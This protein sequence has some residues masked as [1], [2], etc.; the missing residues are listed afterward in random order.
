MN[1]SA[2]L[3]PQTVLTWKASAWWKSALRNPFRDL[4]RGLILFWCLGSLS[5]SLSVFC[6]ALCA[7][8]CPSHHKVHVCVCLYMHSVL[9]CEKKRRKKRAH[10]LNS[11]RSC[12]VCRRVGE[13]AWK[14]SQRARGKS[15]WRF[16]IM[17]RQRCK[18]HRNY[19]VGCIKPQSQ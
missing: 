15:D 1:A 17:Y 11:C 5:L 14:V 2:P 7:C 10:K 6:S 12:C 9:I 18:G 13:N 19:S 8:V 3:P 16:G 4:L